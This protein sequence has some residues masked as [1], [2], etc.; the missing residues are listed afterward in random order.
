MILKSIKTERANSLKYGETIG[1][2]FVLESIT[3][4][5]LFLS[6]LVRGAG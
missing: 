2:S 1:L 4:D 6:T 3:V 5:R